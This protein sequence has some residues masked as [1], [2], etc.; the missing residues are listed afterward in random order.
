MIGVTVIDYGHC[1]VLYAVFLEQFDAS[2]YGGE[3]VLAIDSFAVVVV[4][5]R[6]AVEGDA[7][8]EIVIVKKT[9]PVIGQEG[10]VRLD[11][12][13]NEEAS[14]V[15]LL[16]FEGAAVETEGAK[17]GFAAM[18][19]KEG[20]GLGLGLEVLLDKNFEEFFAHNA[21]GGGIEILFV[22]II[23]VSATEIAGGADRLQHYVEGGGEGRVDG[24]GGHLNF[25]CF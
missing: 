25:D 24:S 10:A 2:E 7:D 17:E 6:R 15:F 5:R 14:A 21:A 22:Q 13:G 19:G 1:V 11:A 3:G 4:E 20:L 23:T 9:T 12:V 8:E 16:K 18:P